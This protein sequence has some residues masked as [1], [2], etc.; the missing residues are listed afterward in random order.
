MPVDSKRH[1]E[2]KTG[3][4]PSREPIELNIEAKKTQS[5]VPL[6]SVTWLKTF[7]W[8]LYFFEENIVA[9]CHGRTK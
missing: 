1:S 8:Y 2:E 4:N 6:S 5:T 7:N 9:P 3:R